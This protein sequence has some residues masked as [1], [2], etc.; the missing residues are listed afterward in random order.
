MPEIDCRYIMHAR[1]YIKDEHHIALLF[2]VNQNSYPSSTLFLTYSI[3]LNKSHLIFI[4]K[5][6]NA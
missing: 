4:M 6:E 1:I 3:Y 5:K 2:V